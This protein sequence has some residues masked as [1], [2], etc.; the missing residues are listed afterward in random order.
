MLEH[1]VNPVLLFAYGSSEKASGAD[2]QQER[3]LVI[4][5]RSFISYNDLVFFNN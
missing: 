1:L 4:F 5:N 3:L 2:N